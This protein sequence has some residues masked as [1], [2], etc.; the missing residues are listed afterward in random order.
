M[1]FCFGF[2]G[3]DWQT[4]KQGEHRET[5]A[6][7]KIGDGGI[8][9]FPAKKAVH[10]AYTHTFIY[11]GSTNKKK[12]LDI[13]S[14]SHEIHNINLFKHYNSA[15]RLGKPF[16]FNSYAKNTFPVLQSIQ[17]GEVAVIAVTGNSGYFKLRCSIGYVDGHDSL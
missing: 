14:Y 3:S 17:A 8:Y 6:V 13:S 9:D 7:W 15:I 1:A 16:L 4:E 12:T 11:D 5:E 2:W 10:F